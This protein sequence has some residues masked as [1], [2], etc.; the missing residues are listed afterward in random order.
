M[1]RK[2]FVNLKRKAM[3]RKKI[4][5]TQS[6]A[7]EVE[8]VYKK[9]E[10]YNKALDK[11]KEKDPNKFEEIYNSINKEEEIVI[12]DEPQEDIIAISSIEIAGLL[13]YFKRL[14]K[15]K[16][17]SVSINSLTIYNSDF[18]SSENIQPVVNNIDNHSEQIEIEEEEEEE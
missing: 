1:S 10:E 2:E 11:L 12:N 17:P 16:E 3:G 5:Y 7:K 18:T 9:L 8:D 13:Y 4:G 15:G 14:L 6:T